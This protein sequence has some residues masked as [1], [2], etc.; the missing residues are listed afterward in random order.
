M[1]AL[2]RQSKLIVQGRVLTTL[3]A[4]QVGASL[5]DSLETPIIVAVDR[6]L[7]GELGSEQATIT[8]LQQGGTLNGFEVIAPESP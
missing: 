7:K 4:V 2:V 3:Q 1:Q 8:V 5:P 6:L